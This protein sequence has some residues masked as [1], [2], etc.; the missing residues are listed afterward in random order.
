MLFRSGRAFD[1]DG[2]TPE[3]AIRQVNACT[4]ED[5]AAAAKRLKPAVAYTLKGGGEGWSRS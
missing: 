2:L 3:E 5:V 4:I 1:Q